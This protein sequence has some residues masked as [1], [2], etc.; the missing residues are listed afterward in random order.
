MICLAL[1][2]WGFYQADQFRRALPA[3]SRQ[4]AP[5]GAISSETVTADDPPDGVSPTNLSQ[6]A[7]L[8]ALSPESLA[9]DT[10]DTAPVDMRTYPTFDAALSAE[11]LFSQGKQLLDSGQI[12]AG[13]FALNAALARI[14]DD[15]RAQQLR[16]LLSDLNVPIFLGSAVLSDDP[17]ARL[18]DIQADDTFLKIASTYGLT[19]GLLQ[20]LNPSL[21]ARD[22]KPHT[23]IKIVQGPL[24]A[25]I[26]KHDHRLDLFARDL[27]VTSLRVDFPEGNYLPRGDYKVSAGTKLQLGPFNSLRTWIGF[28][29][30]EDATEQVESG[31]IFGSAGPRG[32]TTRDLATGVQLSDSDMQTLFVTL[33]EGHSH[34][35]VE[36]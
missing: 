11:D 26:V 34:V 7:L 10:A 35:R 31:W 6:T 23:G 25:R 29:G 24:H 13:R 21:A 36:P 33:T 9:G 2:G 1:V 22:L 16:T 15:G 20:T 14:S 30:V 27:F 19:A 32:H 12:V 4:D 17:A 18:V 28:H 3:V 8:P 5:P